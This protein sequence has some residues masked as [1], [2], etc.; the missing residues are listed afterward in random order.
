VITLA[1]EHAAELGV[2]L[3]APTP[4]RAPDGVEIGMQLL[5]SGELRLR[6]Q[7]SIPM[8]G[9]AEAHQLLEQGRV[10]HKLLLTTSP[11]L[12]EVAN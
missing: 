10:H 5:G 9:A 4:D 2:R 8:S 6:S 3:S 12:A 1:D 7:Q 11:E